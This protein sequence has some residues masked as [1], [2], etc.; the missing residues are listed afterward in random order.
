VLPEAAGRISLLE[1]G[2][3]VRILDLAEQLIRLS[4]L[5]PYKDVQI[6]FTGLR[7][8]EKLHE[9]LLS[10]TEYAVETSADK[11]R[12]VERNG[13]AADSAALARRLRNLRVAAVQRD[14][15]A[16]V[17]ALSALVPE[18]RPALPELPF[19]RNGKHTNGRPVRMNLRARLRLTVPSS[20]ARTGT[21]D[22]A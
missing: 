8:G 5:V 10:P 1:M 21:H 12:V 17:R 6:V 11:I 20:P 7:P 4:G 15:R 18:Y 16:I 19:R 13:T 14:E 3:Q 22:R 9:E 2:T